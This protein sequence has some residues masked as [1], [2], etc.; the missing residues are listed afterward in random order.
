[1]AFAS[2]RAVLV[3]V[4]EPGQHT[5]S[6]VEEKASGV[7]GSQRKL[8]HGWVGRISRQTGSL[9]LLQLCQ[10]YMTLCVRIGKTA[11]KRL[12]RYQW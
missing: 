4:P 7:S 10:N 11:I 12:N 5:S 8:I 3:S 6:I 9:T 1:M 2:R